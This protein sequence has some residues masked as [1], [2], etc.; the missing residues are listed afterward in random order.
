MLDATVASLRPIG[1]ENR[2]V[3]VIGVALEAHEAHA[4]ASGE[5]R[6]DELVERRDYLV[7]LAQVPG[8]PVKALA[9]RVGGRAEPLRVA[10]EVG[11]DVLD[12]I[13]GK[14]AL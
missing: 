7:E 1:G 3:A 12:S 9:V 4:L 2:A 11:V 8:I 10:R 5:E 6:R 14:R 13:R